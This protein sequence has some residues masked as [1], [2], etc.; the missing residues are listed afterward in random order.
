MYR[1]TASLKSLGVPPQ[2]I[3]EQAAAPRALIGMRGV[4]VL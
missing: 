2:A 1:G 3:C 4:V